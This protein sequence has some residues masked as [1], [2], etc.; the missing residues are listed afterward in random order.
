MYVIQV[1]MSL[2]DSCGIFR[3]VCVCFRS[4]KAACLH[5]ACEGRHCNRILPELAF[6]R[7]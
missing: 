1:E 2:K 4:R 3:C 5:E 7:L 6:T